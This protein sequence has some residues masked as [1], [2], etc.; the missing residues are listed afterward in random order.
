MNLSANGWGEPDERGQA[1]RELNRNVD[2]RKAVTMALDRQALGDSLVKGPFTAI[3]PG[4]LSCRH[5]LLRQGT[6]PS[7]IPSISKAPR[8]NSPRPA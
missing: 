3:Y 5:E 8:Q 7:T 6:R 2:F 4:G 1:I